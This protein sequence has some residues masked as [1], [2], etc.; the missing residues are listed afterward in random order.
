MSFLE[1][2]STGLDGL[3]RV[4][5]YLRL[6]DNVVW[7]VNSIDEYR[8]LVDA[9]V[10]QALQ[11]GRRL[12]YMKFGQEAALPDP[13]PRVQVYQLHPESGFESFSTRVHSIAEMEG[14]GVFYIFDCLS[15]LLSAWATD[16]MIGN[17]FRVTCPYLFELD[18]IAYFML[19]RDRNSHQT[20]ARI[21]ETTQLL[22][23]VYTFEDHLYVH[24]LKV[25]N[26]YSPTMFLPHIKTAEDFMPV[27]NSAHAAEL[28]QHLKGRFPSNVE[29]KLDY[30]DRV[31]LTAEELME[32]KLRGE[33]VDATVESEM[34]ANLCKMMIGRE[35]QI[36]ELA[37]RYFDLSDLLELKSRLMG[38]G[39]IGGKSVGMLLARKILMLRAPEHWN[40]HLEAHD[41]FYIGS[42][43]FY[44]YLVEN[45]CWELRL[46][47]KNADHYLEAALELRD[48][49]VKGKLPGPIREELSRMM[50]HFGQSPVI[51]RSSSLLEDAFGNAFAGKYESV[52]CT[53]QG[54]PLDR[55]HAFER[56]LKQVYASTMGEDA[57]SYRL[58]R[59]LA[60]ND[61][62]MAL[63]VMRVSGSYRSRY[64]FPDLAGVA[65]SHNPYTWREDMDPAAGMMRLVF[66]LGTRAVD[67]VEH[68]Y[69]RIVALDKPL[70]QPYKSVDDLRRY[71]QH[72]VDVLNISSNQLETV[73]LNKVSREHRLLPYWDLVAVQDA[74]ARRRL[75]Q[76]GYTDEEIWVLQFDKLLKNTNFT[77]LMS[78]LLHN[79]EEAYSYP[80]DVEF[81]LNFGIDNKIKI[82]LLQCRP[83]QINRT[84]VVNGKPV[85]SCIDETIFRS[86]G[87]FMGIETFEH[88]DRIVYVDTECYRALSQTNQ[89]QVARIVGRLNRLFERGEGRGFMLIG[90][91]RWGST[92]PSLG[93]PVSF[94]EICNAAALVEVAGHSEGFA[95]ELS[96]GTH[97]FQ[98]LVETGIF[99]VALFTGRDT[100]DFSDLYL[101]EAP[102]SLAHYLPEFSSW[103]NV[104]RVVEPENNGQM[105]WLD[106]DI[107]NREVRLYLSS[108]ESE[109]RSG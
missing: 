1:R 11:E 46:K 97:F 67:R 93:I 108:P 38:S 44:T 61:E 18:T 45:G 91:G 13:P 74:D 5:D 52:F 75:R 26:R 85:I 109:K 82:N 63:L 12:V 25:W 87:D 32:R 8:I 2:A 4:V 53:N 89:F 51:V 88:I 65:F 102:N 31:F 14:R 16:L 23:D 76:L 10:N 58:Q 101:T 24:P 98:D 7:Q 69:P 84:Q 27:T 40:R 48:R 77:E 78:D 37:R 106:A 103:Q 55:F 6:G 70:V 17:F 3:D 49:I 72:Y 95:P 99:Y 30:W 21:R 34:I 57:L 64:F 86:Q 50:E 83:L 22:M 35:T 42:D 90:P 28:L 43:V 9:F 66:G 59:G 81:A 19:L 54:S 100:V 71:S 79:L 92:T 68:D 47:Q 20:V 15:D 105:A 39:Y 96:Y 36:L 107:N 62:Q 104:I 29:R 73:P 94:A 60:Q 33:P 41:S 56:A 80:V